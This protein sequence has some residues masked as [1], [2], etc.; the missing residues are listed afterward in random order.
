MKKPGR[1]APCPCGS[2]LKYKRCCEGKDIAAA[3]DEALN[4]LEPEQE[5]EIRLHEHVY[6]C[7][8]MGVWLAFHGKTGNMPSLEELENFYREIYGYELDPSLIDDI[9]FPLPPRAVA[10]LL[11]PTARTTNEIIDLA[12]EPNV[13]PPAVAQAELFPIPDEKPDST[14]A[15]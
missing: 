6:E 11:S 2:G 8:L 5:A 15:R 7:I 4:S 10:Q 1:N 12:P 3:L 13:N 14:S 9:I